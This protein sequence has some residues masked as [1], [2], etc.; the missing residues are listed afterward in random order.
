MNSGQQNRQPLL[1]ASQD[2]HQ[3]NGSE[4]I[5][6]DNF[7]LEV[8]INKNKSAVTLLFLIYLLT[9]QILY[10][11]EKPFTDES[12]ANNCTERP[13]SSCAA[14]I[15]WVL[16]PL[17][18]MRS[19][20]LS[21]YFQEDRR[22]FTG[23]YGLI[24]L[25]EHITF[26]TYS[27]YGMVELMTLSIQ[28]ECTYQSFTIHG[29]NMF[30]IVL[31]G[32]KVASIIFLVASFILCCS[33]CLLVLICSALVQQ[34][35]QHAVSQELIQNLYSIPYDQLKRDSA[36]QLPEANIAECSICLDNFIDGKGTHLM[37]TPMPCD[38]RHF[39]HTKCI[40][41]WFDSSKNNCPLCKEIITQS[42]MR[43]LPLII[44]GDF[45]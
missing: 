35:R 2:L 11:N 30:L 40:K 24:Q 42:Q 5:H 37:V 28:N 23:C 9:C 13:K 10:Q 25:F 31:S 38:V 7:S 34:R 16:I 29:F 12:N 21:S 22:R 18:V 39:F 26:G 45:A 27:I 4:N 19:M 14:F 6:Q 1:D 32:I 36:V 3:N 15:L 41:D 20:L 8:Q 33:P 17:Y 43:S 44:K